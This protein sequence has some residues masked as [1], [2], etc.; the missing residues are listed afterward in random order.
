MCATNEKSGV[1]EGHN[2]TCYGRAASEIF[3]SAMFG[4]LFEMLLVPLTF[5]NTHALFSK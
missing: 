1:E 2:V 5:D 3:I 4:T